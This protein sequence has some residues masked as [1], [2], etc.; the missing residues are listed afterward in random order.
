MDEL[1]LSVLFILFMLYL[2]RFIKGKIN[3]PN[4]PNGEFYFK[5]Y[6]DELINKY[7]K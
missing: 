1:L 3:H 5:S 6:V 2:V 4:Q 7:K